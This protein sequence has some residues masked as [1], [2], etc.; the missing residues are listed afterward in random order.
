MALEPITSFLYSFIDSSPN[1]F[2]VT[3]VIPEPISIET[4]GNAVIKNNGVTCRDWQLE[5]T[6]GRFPYGTPC[7]AIQCF[8]S[9]Y[10]YTELFYSRSMAIYSILWSMSQCFIYFVWFVQNLTEKNLHV[11]C[12]CYGCT[13]EVSS[14]SMGASLGYIYM[15]K[16]CCWHFFNC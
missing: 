16:I 2:K 11:K 9:Y 12:K 1:S 4:W 15:R 3:T 6:V 10:V 5:S 13:S 7:A 8:L 14:T